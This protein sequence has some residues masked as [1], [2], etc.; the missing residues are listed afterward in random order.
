MKVYCLGP[1]QDR[2]EI[3]LNAD[4]KITYIRG[5]SF[6]EDALSFYRPI[7]DWLIDYCNLPDAVLR[8]ELKYIYLNTATVKELLRIFVRLEKL[9]QAGVDIKIMW[10][11]ADDDE[12]MLESGRTLNEVTL[13]SFEFISYKFT[14]T[15]FG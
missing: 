9:F 15:E 5:K 7:Q 13:L 8:L 4:K 10:Y 3:L 2:P 6:M 1:H 11:Y 14:D 12:D